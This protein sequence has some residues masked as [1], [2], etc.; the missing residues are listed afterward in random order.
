[1][2]EKKKDIFIKIS[3]YFCAKEKFCFPNSWEINEIPAIERPIPIE[4][5]KNTTGQVKLVAANSAV[6]NFPSQKAS[7]REYSC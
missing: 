6:P 4:L 3:A 2:I 7:A 5:N 1:M